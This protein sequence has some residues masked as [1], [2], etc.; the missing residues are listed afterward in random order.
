MEVQYL[1]YK[2]TPPAPTINCLDQL[3]SWFIFYFT[4]NKLVCLIPCQHLTLFMQLS[5]FPRLE[6]YPSVRP[7]HESMQELKGVGLGH[8]YMKPTWTFLKVK[9]S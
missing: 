6:K 1:G 5:L 4:F 8:Q 9:G 2:L 7:L 3:L